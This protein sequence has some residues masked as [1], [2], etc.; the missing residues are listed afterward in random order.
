MLAS[1]IIQSWSKQRFEAEEERLN[2]AA[3][4]GDQTVY[5][6]MEAEEGYI[7]TARL[8]EQG[9]HDP[10]NQKQFLSQEGGFKYLDQLHARQKN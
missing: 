1:E 2:Q 3:K 9:L 6:V 7:E 4:E 8:A 10:D 5:K